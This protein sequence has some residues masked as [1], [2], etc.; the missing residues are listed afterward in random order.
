M[1]ERQIAGVVIPPE[2]WAYARLWNVDE[3]MPAVLDTA[4]RAFP[5][6]AISLAL[7]QPLP[8][9]AFHRIVLQVRPGEAGEQQVLD[10]RDGYYRAMR[11]LLGHDASRFRLEWEEPRAEE[12]EEASLE[13]PPTV[14]DDVWRFAMKWRVV[15]P[16]LAVLEMTR[17]IF[18]G[19]EPGWKLENDPELAG[20]RYIVV[21]VLGKGLDVSQGLSARRA[22]SEG[23]VSV[24]PDPARYVFHLRLELA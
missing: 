10:A 12:P 1:S 13:K 11:D 17:T 23:L 21:H 7:D 16:L 18:P 22:W 19:C 2:V 15:K 14:P 5:G 20:D 9:L 4:Q 8:A 3:H 24:C 6:A